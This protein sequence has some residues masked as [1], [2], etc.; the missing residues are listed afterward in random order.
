MH[1]YCALEYHAMLE[2]E[3]RRLGKHNLDLRNKG[4]I[5]P[6]VFRGLDFLPGEI[7][8]SRNYIN[9]DNI[10]VESDFEHPDNQKCFL[11]LAKEIFKRYQEQHNAGIFNSHDCNDF[12][13]PDKSGLGDW[14][15]AVSPF[16]QF[17][18]PSF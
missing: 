6:S 9:F 8:T 15:A 5:F 10:L 12:R 18:M 1:P 7:R 2:L 4:L 3:R 17:D 13:F 11:E 14:L 16:R